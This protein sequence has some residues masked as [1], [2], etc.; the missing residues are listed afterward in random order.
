MVAV[1][2]LELQLDA[3]EVVRRRMED[4]PV[5]ARVEPGRELAD[6]PVAV[7]AVVRDEIC[8]AEELDSHSAGRCAPAGV[9]NVRRERNR[10]AGTLR[11]EPATQPRERLDPLGPLEV[12]QRRQPR[13][14]AR[15][16]RRPRPGAA[17]RGASP[18][19]AARTGRPRAAPA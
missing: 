16:Y 15:A 14:R 3:A 5:P 8:V 1:A 17:S 2:E 19:S 9:E 18:R 6:P 12:A 4:E 10:H 13:G 7:S 11:L